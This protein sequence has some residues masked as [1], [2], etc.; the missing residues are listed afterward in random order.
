MDAF[1]NDLKFN[2]DVSD[3][4]YWGFFS[5]CGLL[6]RYLELYRSEQGI[7]PWETVP[8]DEIA[9]WIQRK[10]SRWQELERMD[11]RSLTI[12]GGTYGPFE[13]AGIN[14]AL[15]PQGLVYGAGQGMYL[16][17]TFFLAELSSVREASG[18][19]V[20]T[21]GRELARDLFSSPAMLQEK[22]IFLRREPLTTLLWE[23]YS[24][25]RRGGGS[26]LEDAFASYGFRPG[27]TVNEDFIGRLERM[28]DRYLEVLLRHELAES[29][30]SV[31]QWKD[32]LASLGDRK[33]EHYLRALK[34]LIADT[35][36]QGPFR[37]IIDSEDRGSLGLTVG[38]MEGYRSVLYP[39]M[40]QAYAS[41]R[42]DRDWALIEEARKRGHER[43]KQDRLAVLNL[44]GGMGGEE[45]ILAVR[46][47]IDQ[48]R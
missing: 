6:M 38:L 39:E 44:H 8:R 37:A 11:F 20:Y 2:C 9:A 18:H 43:F 19:T 26:A 17:P 7:A 12:G 34:D 45:F 15:A 33:A 47:M 3:A 40:K 35:S 13:T 30:E 27:E 48:A 10:E 29:V 32:I 41:F 25:S 4:R 28:T 24:A 16:K 42:R 36:D 22:R 5:I 1:L 31:P 14:D 23:K 46:N 21:S